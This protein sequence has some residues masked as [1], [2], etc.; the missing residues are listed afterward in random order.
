M[1]IPPLALKDKAAIV[2]IGS[3]AFARSLPGSERQLAA[4]AVLQALDDAGLE[5]S[6]VDG[7][8]SYSMELT[9]E[10]ELARNLGFGD[11][12]WFARTPAGGGGGCATVGLAATAIATG[13]A[14]VVVAWRARKRGARAS[15]PWGQ[16][17]KQV[18]GS[19]AFVRP[20]GVIRPVDEIAMLARRYMHETGATR[21]HLANIAMTFRAHAQRNPAALMGGRPLTH[22]DYFSARMISEP[23]CLYDNC[24]ESDG[25][26]AVVLT[27]ADRAADL[28]SP[29]AYVHAFAQGVSAGSMTMSNFFNEDPL[30][31]QAHVCAR[32]LWSHADIGPADVDVAQIYD[33]FT[34]L[35]LFALEAYGF[36]GHGEAAKLTE[37]NG[38]GLG[39]M[40]PVNTSGGSLSEAYIH[41]YNLITEAV[42]QIRGTSTAQV[43][44]AQW[45]F[46]SSSDNVPTSALL[47]RR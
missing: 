7:L 37:D 29:P 1:T 44:D 47:L 12:G 43:P 5:P 4:E 33:A 26:V 24:L 28:P 34:P 36:C 3:T 31:T 27:S 45:S 39:G 19:D 17:S 18:S 22:H 42:R 11:I 23:L 6:H 13:Q 2:G 30:C 41:G 32:A 38:L 46:V 40:L 9:A 20:F 25:A 35:V 14:N 10:D 16:I 8:C 21:E 15:R